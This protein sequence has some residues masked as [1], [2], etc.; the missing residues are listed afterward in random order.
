MHLLKIEAVKLIYGAKE[1]MLFPI[2][3]CIL[4]LFLESQVGR[5]F[6]SKCHVF[7]IEPSPVGMLGLP[8]AFH[9]YNIEIY[10]LLV[11]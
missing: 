6:P 3:G 10:W 7:Q 4:A 9:L 5:K 1:E 11:I 2:P 8:S